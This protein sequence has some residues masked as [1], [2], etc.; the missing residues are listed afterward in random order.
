M[1]TKILPP[2]GRPAKFTDT[3]IEA[4]LQGIRNGLT[5]KAACKGAGISYSTLAAW[6]YRGKVARRNG[7]ENKFTALQEK[8]DAVNTAVWLERRNG[9]YGRLKPRDYRYGWTKG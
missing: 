6:V 1:E 7:V 3:V 2:R 8:I 5:L 4:I 9:F